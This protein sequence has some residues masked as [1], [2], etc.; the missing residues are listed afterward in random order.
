M[1]SSRRVAVSGTLTVKIKQWYVKQGEE[2]VK[3]AVL[4][5]YI[6]CGEQSPDAVVVE[7]KLKSRF[8]GKV[9]KILA[10][11]DEQVPPRLFKL[12]TAFSIQIFQFQ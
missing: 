7:R 10:K 12:C 8:N 2:I 9:E 1:A 3:D 5:S 6:P 4:A 11:Q